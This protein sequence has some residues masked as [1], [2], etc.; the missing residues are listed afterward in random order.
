M[1]AAG[2]SERMG[3]WKM[4]LPWGK[5]TIIETSV[6]HALTACSRIILVSGWAHEELSRLFDA[7]SWEEQREKIRIVKSANW[8]T[9]MFA[10]A[11]C[12]FN[13]ASGDVAGLPPWCF[14]CLG[15]MPEVSPGT[16]LRAAS[17]MDSGCLAGSV[18]PQFKGKKGH[19]V[20]LSREAVAYA[21]SLSDTDSMRDVISAFPSLVIPACEIGVLNDIDTP[22]DYRKHYEK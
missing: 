20:L 3:Q 21:L 12:G 4:S 8:E 5:S 19:P 14:L 17:F 9:G 22:E 15:D 13:A 10:S 6:K 1:L 18:I 7:P 16:Y 2:K 11:C